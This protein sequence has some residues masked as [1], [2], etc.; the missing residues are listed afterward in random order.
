MNWPHI[1]VIWGTSGSIKGS[2]HGGLIGFYAQAG[3]KHRGLA[4]SMRGLLLW[5]LGLGLAGYLAGAAALLVWLD[6]KPHN[7]ITY[8]DLVENLFLPARWPRLEAKRGQ[9]MIEEGL[10]DLDEKKWRA[11]KTML[12]VGLARYPQSTK[13]R[14]KLAGLLV[15]ISSDR[16]QVEELL[17]QGL[18]QG[19]PGHEY[20]SYLFS[21]AAQGENYDFWLQ[22]CDTVLAQL[23][24]QKTLAAERQ[25]VVRQKLS[26][27][28][29]AERNDQALQLAEAEGETQ[30]DVMREFKVLALLKEGKPA[31]AVD[32]LA[33]W[34][35]RILL[36]E[37]LA[38]VRRL[39]ARA[40]REAGRPDDMNRVLD[41][42]RDANPRAPQ[43]P[44]YAI[45]QR[46]LAGR[47]EEAEKNFA[48]YLTLF[49]SKP[50]NLM[51]LA[52]P[53][54]EIGEEAM[55]QRL[56]T[57]SHQQGQ[58]VLGLQRALTAAQ[59]KMAHWQDA[60]TTLAQMGPAI[61]KSDPA[62]VFWLNWMSTLIAAASNPAADAQL[63][64]VELNH[65]RRLPLRLYHDELDALR[66][67]G[68]LATE[69]EILNYA[70]LAYPDSAILRERAVPLAKELAAAAPAGPDPKPAAVTVLNEKEFF[71][72]LTVALGAGDHTGVL[73]QIREIRS[74]RPGWLAAHDDELRRAEILA[75]AGLHD[76]LALTAAASLWLNGSTDRARA[77]ME[78]ATKLHGTDTTAEAV[79]LLELVVRKTPGFA[80][81]DRLLTE[82]R[83]A[84]IGNGNAPA[85]GLTADLG[86]EAR[87]FARLASTLQAGNPTAALAQIHTARS[88]R[89]A[90][91]AAREEELMRDEILSQAHLHDRVNL[92]SLTRLYLNGDRARSLAILALAGQLHTAE[93]TAEAVLLVDEVL[94]KTPGFAPATRQLTEWAAPS[95]GK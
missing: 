17:R 61:P 2:W 47:R 23:A 88:A 68:R 39:Q 34:R 84:P 79:Q 86:S 49:G 62:A 67:A 25:W 71:N 20:L 53:L 18:S 37:G 82:W 42:L 32:F 58:P 43:P 76:M 15:L 24:G 52:E 41:E 80:P 64:L 57:E 56:I 33:G 45:V 90:W 40:F 73:A 65:H 14:L 46:L 5:G 55:L 1:R 50:A 93:T 9:D 91:L 59:V 27:L 83:P 60:T 74:N 44:V 78:L 13:G 77:G 54:A 92:T 7:S 8:T 28:L 11:A 31:E 87:F 70:R 51:L 81:A 48:L 19:Y 10:A 29:A 6:R 22:A 38:Q 4:L 75:H 30:S 95:T 89:P 16:H 35:A 94:R 63:A 12:E 72:Q 69:M 26:A 36:P 85:T 21:F 3:S 66:Q